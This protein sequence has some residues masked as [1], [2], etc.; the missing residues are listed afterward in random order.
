MHII[1]YFFQ[2]PDIASFWHLMMYKCDVVYAKDYIFPFHS[3]HKLH[4]YY[5]THTI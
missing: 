2:S 3:Y 5:I 4:L 1:Y